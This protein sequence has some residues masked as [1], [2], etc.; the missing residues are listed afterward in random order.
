LSRRN[1]RTGRASSLLAAFVWLLVCSF[2]SCAVAGGGAHNL[3]LVVNPNDPASLEV[4]NCYVE[5][6]RIPPCNVF[7][8][9]WMVDARATT[10]AK[11]RDQILKPVMDEIQKRGLTGQIDYLAFSSGFPYLIDCAP[12]FEGQ[13][14]PRQARPLAS[15]NSATYLNQFLVHAH[16]AMFLAANSNSYYAP[17]KNGVTTSRA[18]SAG[19]KWG[20]EG[21][22]VADNGMKYLIC[23][24][25]GVTHGHGNSVAEI[26]A[27]LRRAR[28]A[29]GAKPR[30]TI[31]YMKNGDVRSTTRDAEFTAAVRELQ[32]LGVKA[33]VQPG[34][35]P[36]ATDVAGL[37]TGAANVSLA[38]A[39]LLP[40]AIV[41]NLTSAGG[42]MLI[43]VETNPQTRISEFIRQG[44]T[45]ASGAV[46]EP[47]ATAAKF[48][49]P[50]IHVHYARGCTL[51]EAFYQSIASP[52]Q[53]LIIGD[54]LCQPW[55]VAPEV[56]VTGVADNA[57]VSDDVVLTPE[58]KYPDARRASRFELFVDGV[59]R[60]S[61]PGRGAF[62]IRAA[63]MPDGW[64]E[65]RVVAIDNTPVAVQGVW[66]AGIQIKRGTDTIGLAVPAKRFAVDSNVQLDV[67]NSANKSVRIVHNSRQ[68]GVLE[69]GNG[70]VEV[71]ATLL[72]K[73][74]VQ[75]YAEQDGTPPARSKPLGIE[76]Y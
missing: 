29:D 31:Y 38:G 1:P 69:G 2:S 70:R 55:A 54:P 32:A 16:P 22:T 13:Q 60:D 45:G 9:P 67:V 41:D 28:A 30:G 19:Q 3:A 20:A 43:R 53:I 42:Q 35:A 62:T 15:I 44:A 56:K 37:T 39:S 6:R 21:Q 65:L 27:S 18:F 71:P 51:G 57:L 8:V 23:T 47:F 73:G 64:H 52:A 36:R 4:A 50:A 33:V 61:I 26:L 10:G 12:V 17:A 25:L 58:A 63:G 66:Q 49:A 48:P 11:L 24:A 74:N 7:Y 14:F 59:L 68:V 34:V 46:V 76:I 72:G 5:L 40:G 75:L